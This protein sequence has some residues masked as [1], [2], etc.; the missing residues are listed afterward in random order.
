MEE[1][2]DN[3]IYM[4][5]KNADLCAKEKL[6]EGDKSSPSKEQNQP[7]IGLSLIH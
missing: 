3:R 5:T 6:P 1:N 4:D 2:S 7:D